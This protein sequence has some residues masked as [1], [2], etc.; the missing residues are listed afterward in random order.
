MGEWGLKVEERLEPS[1][2]W[3]LQEAAAKTEL[4]AKEIYWREYLDKDKRRG[5]RTGQGNF[6]GHVSALTSMEREVKER[7]VRGG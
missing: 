5:C 2:S 7:H 3:L 4:E 6:S 1:V